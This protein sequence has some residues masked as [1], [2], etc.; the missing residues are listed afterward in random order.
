MKVIM[1]PKRNNGARF[2]YSYAKISGRDGIST[3][4]HHLYVVCAVV[5]CIK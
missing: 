1:D 2:S 5:L 4:P 3:S